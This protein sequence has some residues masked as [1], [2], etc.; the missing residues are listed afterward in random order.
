MAP[1]L[2]QLRRR[3]KIIIIWSLLGL[4]AVGHRAFKYCENNNSLICSLTT[5]DV[6]LGAILFGLLVLAISI[7]VA[8]TRTARSRRS[9]RDGGF[10]NEPW[11]FDNASIEIS[12]RVQRILENSAGDDLR[13]H[14]TNLIRTVTKSK[15]H[16][17]RHINQ[18]FL[19]SSPGLRNNEQL[20]VVVNTAF[21]KHRL[22]EGAWVR[23]RGAYIHNQAKRKGLFGAKLSVYGLLHKVHTPH[24]FLHILPGEPT[25]ADCKPQSI[26]TQRDEVVSGS[27]P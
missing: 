22:R 14:A 19:L 7:V 12:G 9:R 15:D 4:L 8:V 24:G 27:T 26:N 25:A 1:G 18:R 3:R 17:G 23:V 5:E 10:K 21:G 13:R 6:L 16:S 20:L 2:R 11:T